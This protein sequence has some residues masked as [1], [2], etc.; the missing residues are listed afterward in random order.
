VITVREID[1]AELGRWVEVHNHARPDDRGTVEGFVDWRRQAE[2]MVWLLATDDG[3]DAVGAGLGLVGWHSR[4]GT[5]RVEAWTAPGREGRGVGTALFRALLAWAA[6]RGCVEVETS[7]AEHDEASRVWADRRGFREIGRELR[8]SLDLESIAAPDIDPPAGVDIVTWAERP[9]LARGMYEVYVEADPD[10]PGSDGVEV[11]A[12][13]EWL[14]DDMEGASDRPEAVFVALAVDE[15]VGYAKLSLPPEWTGTAWHDLTG[16]KRAWR[17]R[18]IA[19]AL[20]R[21]QI[22]WAKEHGFKRLTTM[23]EERNAPIRHL[24]QRYGYT[25]E[26]GRIILATKISG[27]D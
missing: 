25:P 20:K 11:P 24:N 17:G 9:E 1:V 13:E 18:G 15:V 26:P 14:A 8:V 2:D 12:F 3:D 22:R 10:I 16:V 6:E 23:N 21:A 19:S 27:I 7:V 5:A 4:P